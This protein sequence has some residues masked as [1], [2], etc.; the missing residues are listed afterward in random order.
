MTGITEKQNPASQADLNVFLSGGEKDGTGVHTKEPLKGMRLQLY[1][2]KCGVASRRAC[3][4]LIEDG[5]VTVNGTIVTELGTKVSGC[6][7]I[8]FDGKKI[9]PEAEKRYILL[10]KPEGYVSTLSDEKNR[11]TAASLLKK[12]FTERLYN[13]GRLDMFS[14]GALIFTNDGE[15]SAKIE[16][17]SAGIEKEYEVLT[18]NSF[19]TEVLE[20][21]LRGVR[22]EGVFYKAK[23]AERLGKCR[24]KIVLTEGKNREI[25]RVLQFFNVKI[26]KLTRIRIG[27]VFL[28][29][30]EPGQFRLLT[31]EEIKGLLKVR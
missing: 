18:V 30:L 12:H 29:S 3:E 16:H 1:L 6:E 19:R 2:A 7:E 26:K 8:C 4:K 15:F 25:R 11:P 22:V 20:R 13:I 23:K 31:V 10:N 9:V 17:P 14:C 21:F 5:R 28:D 24:M 27:S